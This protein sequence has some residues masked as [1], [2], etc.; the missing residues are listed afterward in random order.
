MIKGNQAVRQ[1][2][3]QA[4]K[5]PYT[6]IFHAEEQGGF[7]VQ[8]LEFPGCYSSGDDATEAMSNLEEAIAVWVED[9]LRQ[10]QV[11]PPP[12]VNQ[13][14]SGRVTLRLPPSLHE[15]AAMFAAAEEVSL[16]RFFAMAIAQ[17]VGERAGRQDLSA[18]PI[19]PLRAVAEEV[20]VYRRPSKRHTAS[21]GRAPAGKRS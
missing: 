12:L 7:S 1:V 21:K 9:Q 14:H 6:R 17:A 4:L 11:I 15:R 19:P 18:P 20:V 3:A 5:T 10:G 2:V 13:E 8:V 16:N